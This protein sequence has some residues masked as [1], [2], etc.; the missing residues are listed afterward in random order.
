MKTS[1]EDITSIKKKLSIEIG[2]E[3]V[4]KK[5][6]KAYR[7]LGKK[8]KVPGFRPGKVPRKILERRFA[9]QVAEDVTR[10]LINESFPRAIE[11]VKTFPLG[12]PSLEKETLKQGQDFMYSAVMEVRPQFGVK[13]YL[14][15]EVEKEKCFVTEEDV[16]NQLEQ[17]R[18][19]HGKLASVEQDRPIRKDDYVVLDYDGFEG[20]RPL[21]SIKSSNFLLKVGSNDFHPRFEESLIGLNKEAEA[22]IKVDFEDSYYNS[23]LAG[24]S[25][26]FKV[27]TIDIKEMILPELNDE[28]VQSLGADFKDLDDL[29]DKVRETT[30]EQEEKRIEREL[31]QRLLEKIMDT[32]DFES[33]QVLI[34]SE[35]DYAVETFKQNLIKSGSSLEKIG[36]SDKRLR[37][38]FR[39]A[40]EKR[41]RE[42]LVLS[43][44]AKQDEIT[45][46]EEDLAG[47]FKELAASTGQDPEDIRRYY[48]ARNLVD[49]LREKLIEE[50]TLNYLVEHAKVSEVERG[51]LIQNKSSEKEKN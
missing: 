14:G 10:D 15:L 39:P 46:D 20:D 13:D 47:T 19:A 50:K 48:E 28:F 21:D 24:R 35:I 9:E 30:T 12:V 8:A 25:V 2:S 31:Y 7:E 45:V 27:K 1:L 11:E 5:L 23:N 18:Q 40:S 51:A 34:E 42:K 37:N 43:E 33:P 38:D 26:N 3:E 22:E 32:V 6:N 4:D 17:I 36:I 16:V 44:I 49:S 29:K 41:V